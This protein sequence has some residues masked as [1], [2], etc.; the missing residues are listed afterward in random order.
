MTGQTDRA[1]NLT[2]LRQGMGGH[3][4]SPATGN[5]AFAC[6]GADMD[7]V[8]DPLFASKPMNPSG[9]L[10]LSVSDGI[11]QKHGNARVLAASPTA[12]HPRNSI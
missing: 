12:I 1:N 5:D 9:G 3:G 11:V 4:G 6:P 2:G 8:F 10:G 7:R